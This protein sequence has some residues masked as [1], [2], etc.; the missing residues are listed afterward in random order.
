MLAQVLE[1]E[2]LQKPIPIKI[3]EIETIQ[4]P[5]PKLG[6]VNQAIEML[7]KGECLNKLIIVLQTTVHQRQTIICSRI[8]VKP[9][10]ITKTANRF[11]IRQGI[12]E[13]RKR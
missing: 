10:S 13:I 3:L 11:L 1:E 5:L 4:E 12:R 8:I 2:C 6:E 7:V 9:N